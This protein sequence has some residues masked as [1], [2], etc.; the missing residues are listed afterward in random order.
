MCGV[1]AH[2]CVEFN[3]IY[4][5]A[6]SSCTYTNSCVCVRARRTRASQR[7]KRLPPRPRTNERA[8]PLPREKQVP[9]GG[10]DWPSFI[11]FYYTWGTVSPCGARRL[12]SSLRRYRRWSFRIS[13]RARRRAIDFSRRPV[14]PPVMRFAPKF[15]I[16]WLSR[17]I[18]DTSSCTIAMYGLFDKSV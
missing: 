5:V 16:I 11:I 1:C 15:R 9:V 2:T 6:V 8:N 3:Y 14:A 17:I 12:L 18:A 4:Y 13:R 10:R 7:T